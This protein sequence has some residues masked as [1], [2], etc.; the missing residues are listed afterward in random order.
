M[1][2]QDHIVALQKKHA[3]LDTALEQEN[4]RPHP[5]DMVIHD[6]KREKL[7]IKDEIATLSNGSM[8]TH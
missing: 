6:L 7:K 4:L 5:D 2:M 1:S 8:G 3:S